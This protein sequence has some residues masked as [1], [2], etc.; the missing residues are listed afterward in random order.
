MST[1]IS[2]RW[3]GPRAAVLA[4]LAALGD[5]RHVAMLDGATGP[6][7]AVQPD[8]RV[9]AFGPVEDRTILGTEAT[10]ALL[11]AHE[12]IPLPDG[13]ELADEAMSRAVVGEFMPGPALEV[14]RAQARVAMAAY[15]LPDGRS[16][17]TATRELLAAQLTATEGLPDSAAARIAAVQAAEWWSAAST[18]RRDHPVLL[19]V[20]QALNLSSGQIDTLFRTAAALTA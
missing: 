8:P 3:C 6:V 20:G 11:L 16:L 4:A 12:E 10:F 7:P 2:L 5:P 9:V 14:T 17:L 13:L 19:R 1:L 18:Y 15:F